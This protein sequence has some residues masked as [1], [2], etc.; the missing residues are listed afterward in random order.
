MD[1]D[2]VCAKGLINDKAQL[3]AFMIAARAL[4]QAGLVLGVDPYVTG[5]AFGRQ[6]TTPK[7]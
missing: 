1:S 7:A 6:W 2:L 3:C 5:V 4:N